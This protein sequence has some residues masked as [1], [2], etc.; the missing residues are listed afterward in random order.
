MQ[1]HKALFLDIDGVMV[2]PWSENQ[3]P[4]KWFNTDMA[5]FTRESVNALNAIV[6]QTGAKII[7]ASDW[8]HELGDHGLMECFVFN[9]VK[10]FPYPLSFDFRESEET[11]DARKYQRRCK[12]IEA[13]LD[14]RN[15]G[16]FVIVDDVALPCFSEHQVNPDKEEGL[17]EAHIQRILTILNQKPTYR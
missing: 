16:G 1:L 15:A 5:P 14:S 3:P 10:A 4:K 6:Q 2:T 7:V 12:E 8:R 13:Y 9:Q 17:Q 11:E